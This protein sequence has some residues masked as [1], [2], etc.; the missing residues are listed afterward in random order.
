M[1][2]HNKNN[3]PAKLYRSTP[4]KKHLPARLMY[5]GQIGAGYDYLTESSS[6]ITLRGDYNEGLINFQIDGECHQEASPSPDNPSQIF[7]FDGLLYLDSVPLPPLPELCK[8]GDVRDT[9]LVD[10]GKVTLT[11]NIGS[12]DE[13]LLNINEDF[14]GESI[15]AVNSYTNWEI[16]DSGFRQTKKRNTGYFCHPVFD[17]TNIVKPNTTYFFHRNNDKNFKI[18]NGI[19]DSFV[20]SILLFVDGVRVDVIYRWDKFLVFTTPENFTSI[21]IY[22]YTVPSN[23]IISEY[24]DGVDFTQFYIEWSEVGLYVPVRPNSAYLGTMTSGGK[25][26]AQGVF[27]VNKGEIIKYQLAEPIT[28]DLTET[29]IGQMLLGINT[30]HGRNKILSAPNGMLTATQYINSR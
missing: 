15:E 5:K 24:A 18:T 7:S 30:E 13:R 16:T 29:P 10:D 27:T 22:T 21:Q 3:I 11:K 14:L 20:G 12:S 17:L 9:V 23:D 25:T 4:S 2:I 6:E 19:S 1:L 8:I 26:N 28:T